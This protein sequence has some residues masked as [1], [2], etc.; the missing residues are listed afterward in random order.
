MAYEQVRAIL[1]LP[2][3]LSPSHAQ[4]EVGEGAGD[5]WG[6]DISGGVCQNR[7]SALLLISC[8][9]E[10]RGMPHGGHLLVSEAMLTHLH[11]CSPL[12]VNFEYIFT[13]NIFCHILTETYFYNFCWSWVIKVVDFWNCKIKLM[14]NFYRSIITGVKNVEIRSLK[15]KLIVLKVV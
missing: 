15:V 3:R 7:C 10:N 6:C 9:G 5:L 1:L 12:L 11:I 4:T 13:W 2:L 8:C 14:F